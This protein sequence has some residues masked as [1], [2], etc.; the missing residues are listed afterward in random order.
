MPT[1]CCASGMQPAQWAGWEMRGTWRTLPCFS[2]PMRPNTSQ[3]SASPSTEERAVGAADS[4]QSEGYG[5]GFN[6]RFVFK[7][8]PQSG[9]LGL[10]SVAL[11]EPVGSQVLVK[12]H[13]ASICG[14]DLH[15]YKWNA[16][17]ARTY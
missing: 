3:A 10:R 17:A 12:I 15:I 9:G 16:W 4:V 14:T 8:R 11:A 13:S 5:M 6:A 2:L 1:R 7:E